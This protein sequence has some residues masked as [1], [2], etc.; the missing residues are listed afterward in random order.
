MRRGEVIFLQQQEAKY[1]FVVFS[2][3]VGMWA[4]AEVDGNIA[5]QSGKASWATRYTLSKDTADFTSRKVCELMYENAHG[6]P[7]D[8]SSPFGGPLPGRC[9]LGDRQPDLVYAAPQTCSR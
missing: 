4:A 9:A 8:I 1:F 2:G 5:V 6:K 7:L 3:E